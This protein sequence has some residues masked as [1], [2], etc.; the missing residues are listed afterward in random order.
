MIGA[1]LGG[2]CR[3]E[4]GGVLLAGPAGTDMAGGAAP[5]AGEGTD[6]DGVA[7]VCATAPGMI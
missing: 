1:P 5:G 3:I 6:N 4:T 2:T 7:G